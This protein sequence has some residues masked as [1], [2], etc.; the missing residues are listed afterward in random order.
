MPIKTLLIALLSATALTLPASAQDA[1][2]G[3]SAGRPVGTTSVSVPGQAGLAGRVDE[4]TLRALAARNDIAGVA[5]E[6]RKLR[7]EN[8]N[9]TPPQDLFESTPDPAEEQRLWA[10]FGQGKLD[11]IPSVIALIQAARPQWR[12]SADF[13]AKFAA[14]KSRREIVAASEAGN[15]VQVVALASAQPGILVC[16]EMDV[17]WRVGEALVKTRA[18]DKAFEL[19][20]YI[21]SRCTDTKE[22]TATVEKAAT[23]LAPD[24]AEKLLT[25]GLQAKDASSF[26]A[27][28]RNVLRSRIARAIDGGPAVAAADLAAFEASALQARQAEDVML[29]GWLHYSRKE[30]PAAVTN[31]EAAMGMVTSPKAIEGFILSHRAMGNICLLYTSPSPR[32]RG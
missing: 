25:I 16:G 15:A 17:L 28:R 30:M 9:W 27:V 13:S 19:Y 23:L 26:E 18:S 21:L 32:D 12:P 14:S 20:S 1:W 31:F 11:E 6:I 29:A 10:L 5:A 8:P 24:Q 4:A 2:T 22:R 7:N 3:L